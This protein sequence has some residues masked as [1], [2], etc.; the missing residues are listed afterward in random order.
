MFTRAYKIIAFKS[1]INM[2]DDILVFIS[3]AKGICMQFICCI[4]K[5]VERCRKDN[6]VVNPF[7][8]QLLI[9]RNQNVSLTLKLC[10]H[11]IQYCFQ[12]YCER[13]I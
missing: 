4:L 8:F 6:K 10:Q 13:R 1:A 9:F 7:H 3:C 11:V 12:F 5:L 2:S